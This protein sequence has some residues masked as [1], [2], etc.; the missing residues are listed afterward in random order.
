MFYQA[1][2]CDLVS[3]FRGTNYHPSLVF[4][5][6]QPADQPS[7]P[8]PASSRSLVV[9]Y[10]GSAVHGSAFQGTRIQLQRQKVIVATGR[11]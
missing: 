11:D 4:A 5:A 1:E 2:A 3:L 10:I 6:W 8:V 7:F 9:V